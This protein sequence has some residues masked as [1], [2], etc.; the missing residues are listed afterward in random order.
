MEPLIVTYSGR[1][2][3]PLALRPEDINIHDIAHHLASINRFVGSLHVPISVAQHSYYVYKLCKGTGWEREALFH[4]AAEAYLGDMTKWVKLHPDMRFFRE[5][6]Q[7]AWLVICEALKLRPEGSPELNSIIE[8]ADRLM[9]RYEAFMLGH[10]NFDDHL[11][12]MPRYQKPSETEINNIGVWK[13]LTWH[14]SREKFL[15]A[16]LMLGYNVEIV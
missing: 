10:K 7:A 4:D 1:K 14:E 5:R 3:N 8:Y 12:S 11:F 9:V 6:E 13:P 16:S 15:H 2:V